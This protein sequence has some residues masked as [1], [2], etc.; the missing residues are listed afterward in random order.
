MIVCSGSLVARPTMPSCVGCCPFAFLGLLCWLLHSRGTPSSQQSR[1]QRGV[2]VGL[3]RTRSW[4]TSELKGCRLRC[5]LC[6]SARKVWGDKVCGAAGYALRL[7][8][9]TRGGLALLLPA[10]L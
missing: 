5:T 10:W 6:P 9:L 7:V 8:G 1:S 2:Y 3:H 4:R